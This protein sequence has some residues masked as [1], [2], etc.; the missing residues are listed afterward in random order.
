MVDAWAADT[1]DGHDTALLAW[2]R[3]DVADLNRLARDRW[4]QPQP[5]HRPR[6]QRHRRPPLRRRRPPRRARPQPG[7][8]IVTSEPLT[9]TA[10][11]ERR[12]RRPHQRRPSGHPHRHGLDAEHLDYGYA[13][14]VH[15]AQGATYDRAHVLAAGGGR[16]LAYVALSRA[17]DHTTIHATADDLDQAVDDLQP[18]GASNTTNAGSPTPPPTPATNPSRLTQLLDRGTFQPLPAPS[19]S[20]QRA[21]AQRRLIDLHDDYDELLAGTGRWADTPA[22]AAARALNAARQQL[23]ETPRAATA[24]KRHRRRDQQDAADP[25]PPA[26]RSPS[27]ALGAAGIRWASPKPDPP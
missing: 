12:H 20:D 17:R 22:G 23:T 11:T 6:R 7:A 1:A 5:P 21:D 25:D 13:L 10:V 26:R 2:R 18:T 8:G 15:R 24:A 14:T 16:E 27:R 19:L 3:A 4:D 9:I